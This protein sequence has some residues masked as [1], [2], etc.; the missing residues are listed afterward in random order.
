MNLLIAGLVVFFVPHVVPWWPAAR[1]ALVSRLGENGY[2]IAFT[3]VSLIGI[4]LVVIGKSRAPFE[5][6]WA[7]DP[8][9]GHVTR[10]LVLLGFILLPAAHMKTNIKRFTRHPM[11]WGVVL[12]GVGHLLSNGDR[13]SAIL[14]GSFVAYS[15]LAMLSANARGARKSTTVYP[16]S[17]DI[18]VVVA[19]VVA[20]GVLTLAHGWLF[21]YPL[22]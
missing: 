13:A 4:V 22:I 16:F 5:M 20:Y 14:F 21:G 8:A 7:V 6:V 9:M 15:L 17:K 2:K 12:W 11:L 1:S 3:I 10:P 19:G 18:M